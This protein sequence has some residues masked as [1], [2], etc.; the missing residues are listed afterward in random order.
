MIETILL[1]VLFSEP[2]FYFTYSVRDSHDL[3]IPLVAE[4]DLGFQDRGLVVSL[5]ISGGKTVVSFPLDISCTV[6]MNDEDSHCTRP[7]LSPTS[8]PLLH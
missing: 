4:T 3:D 2:I 7:S 6:G 1:L 8:I 5:P